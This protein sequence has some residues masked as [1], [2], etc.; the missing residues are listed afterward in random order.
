MATCENCQGNKRR[1]SGQWGVM[2][3]QF[4]KAT[5]RAAGPQHSSALPRETASQLGSCQN[6]EQRRSAFRLMAAARGIAR[7]ERYG[8]GSKLGRPSE[9][10][11]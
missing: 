7:S 3:E 9:L 6:I 5:Q 1:P 11:F 8:F 4:A 2:A 10:P